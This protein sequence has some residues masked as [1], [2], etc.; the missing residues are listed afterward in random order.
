[1][2]I[3]KSRNKYL[4]ERRFVCGLH[5]MFVSKRADILFLVRAENSDLSISPKQP[6]HHKI[7]LCAGAIK[8]NRTIKCKQNK[9]KTLIL[10]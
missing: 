7:L 3:I 5:Y 1:M 9:S 10:I 2:R 4:R 8:L 6:V